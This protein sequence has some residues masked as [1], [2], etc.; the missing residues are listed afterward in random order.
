MNFK[1]AFGGLNDSPALAGGAR[2]Y[3]RSSG[4]F[5]WTAAVNAGFAIIPVM[6]DIQLTFAVTDRAKPVI[7]IL[8]GAG[9]NTGA[10][11]EG[12]VQRKM[13]MMW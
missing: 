13:S 4:L 5:P 6:M 2:F 7:D 8:H 3:G 10:L 12:A 9:M 1:F 11:A